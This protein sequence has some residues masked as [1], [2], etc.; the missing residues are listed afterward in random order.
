VTVFKERPAL[1][2]SGASKLPKQS[3]I[4]IEVLPRAVQKSRMPGAGEA[5]FDL[6]KP[7]I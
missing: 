7:G 4:Q 6:R 1:W 5:G 3:V 2:H